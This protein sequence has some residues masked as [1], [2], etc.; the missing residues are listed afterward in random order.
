MSE[1]LVPAGVA[2]R[3]RSFWSRAARPPADEKTN[4]ATEFS[5]RCQ[6]KYPLNRKTKRSIGFSCTWLLGVLICL[7]KP[8]KDDLPTEAHH[9]GS[10]HSPCWRVAPEPFA[11]FC[12]GV[13]TF[14]GIVQ[15]LVELP[16]A[17]SPCIDLRPLSSAG[18]DDI[19]FLNG[20]LVLCWRRL[21]WLTEIRLS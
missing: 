10:Y 2:R 18:R 19:H 8:E 3:T 9:R 7:P 5:D 16:S 15:L 11:Q 14:C 21:S 12:Q 17:S 6:L 20:I 1:A 4:S 13:S